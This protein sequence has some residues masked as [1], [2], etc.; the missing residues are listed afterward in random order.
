M[1]MFIPLEKRS[2]KEQREYHKA[3][4]GMWHEFSPVTRVVPSG[5]V[6]KRSRN[7]RDARR[8]GQV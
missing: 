1:N 4:R 2:K 5:K 3:R 6:Y 8:E 7:K